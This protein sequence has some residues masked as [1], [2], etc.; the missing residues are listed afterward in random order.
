MFELIHYE[1]LVPSNKYKI[2]D[3]VYIY[4]KTWEAPYGIL[5]LKFFDLQRENMI[6]FRFFT[7]N[8]K[9]YQLI[10]QNPQWEMERRSVNMIIRRILGDEYFMW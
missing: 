1:K 6:R 10:P 5:Y 2:N 7:T 4:I 3:K 9:I 8:F